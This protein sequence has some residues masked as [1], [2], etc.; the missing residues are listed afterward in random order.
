[1][2]QLAQ[3]EDV[4][5]EVFEELGGSFERV[6]ARGVSADQIV[7]DPGLGFAKTEEQNLEILAG[8]QRFHSWGRPLLVGPSRKSFIGA[9]IGKPPRERDGGTAA[10]VTL[11]VANGAHLVRVHDVRTMQ[12]VVKVAQAIVSRRGQAHVRS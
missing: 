1:M 6:L 10:A 9:L 5:G 3:Y 11:A 8:L 7:L 4:V 2:Q 12:D